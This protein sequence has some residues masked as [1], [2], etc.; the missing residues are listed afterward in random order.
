[1][2]Q[3]FNSLFN[4]S[5]DA[6][7]FSTDSIVERQQEVLREM[8]RRRDEIN[9]RFYALQDEFEVVEEE[10]IVVP[11]EVEDPIEGILRD[12]RY[13]TGDTTE[14]FLRQL[15][16]HINT[17]SQNQSALE[18]EIATLKERLDET[19]FYKEAS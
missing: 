17:L 6:V 8:E 3:W 18:N 1:M 19:E 13:E 12:V 9:E 5:D 14:E 16:A 2:K 7:R 4:K 15:V 10:T 11:E